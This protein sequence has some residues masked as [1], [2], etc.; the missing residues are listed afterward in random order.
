M[1]EISI[2]E[3]TIE[4]PQAALSSRAVTSVELVDKYLRRISAYDCRGTA[5]NSIPIINPNVFAEAAASDDRRASRASPRPR[6]GILFTVKDSYKVNGLTVASGS[7]AF[8][9]LIANEDAFTVELIRAAGGVLIGKNSMPSMAYGGM[10]RG[11]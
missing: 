8:K 7:P 10:Q 3:A 9:D 5:L 2:V 4:E 1:A 6:E 11:I